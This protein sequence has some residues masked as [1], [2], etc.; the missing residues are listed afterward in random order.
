MFEHMNEELQELLRFPREDLDIELKQWMDIQDKNVQAKFAKE[1]LA[2]RN[3]GGG[4]LVIGFIDGNPPVPDPNRPASLENFSTDLFNT[5]IKRYA[6]PTFHCMVHLV[7][8]PVTGELYPVIV[9]PGGAKVPVRCKSDSPDGGKSAKLDSYYIRRPGPESSPPQTGTDWDG[10]LQRCLLARKE[11]LLSSLAAI[12]GTGPTAGLLGIQSLAKPVHPFAELTAFRDAA[13]KK[14]E[15]MQEE[16]LPEDAG[17]RLAHGRYIFSAR[18]LGEL[19]QLNPHEIVDLLRGLKRYSGWSPMYIFNRKELEPYPAENDI[20]EC[21]LGRSEQ[22]DPGHA[23]FWRVSPSG[24]I[25]LI[26]G[27]QEDGSD[28]VN[29]EAGK[30]PGTL[31]ELTLPVWRVAEFILRVKEFGGRMAV[32][33]YRLQFLMEWEGLTGRT[34]FSH[35]SRRIMFGESTAHDD[36]YRTEVEV[37]PAEVDAALGSIVAKIVTP[38]L[39]KFSFFEPPTK[40][41][42]EELRH[43]LGREYT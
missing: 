33:D 26:R 16:K 7:A 13:V 8:H 40:L 34:L 21:W 9:V 12:L 6:E 43:M 11:E 38:L 28:F 17:A 29:E 24:E 30:L 32:G 14:L 15:K 19:K 22:R 27:H 3:H 1:L 41:V 2:L 18:I 35:N 25:V 42:D 39:R 37:A 10:L 5:I 20:V 23:D 31:F 36:T 4:Y